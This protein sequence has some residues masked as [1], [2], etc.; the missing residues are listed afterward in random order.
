MLLFITNSIKTPARS[1]HPVMPQYRAVPQP[2]RGSTHS[3]KYHLGLMSSGTCILRYGN[4][5]RKTTSISAPRKYLTS[6]SISQARYPSAASRLVKRHAKSV[7]GDVHA[8][9]LAGVLQN[10]EPAGV[11]FPYNACMSITNSGRLRD[12]E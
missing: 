1:R 8:L 6:L 7:H 3:F 10:H 5:A 12:S 11:V 2:V 4:E 9:L